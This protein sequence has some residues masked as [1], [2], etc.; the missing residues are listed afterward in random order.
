MAYILKNYSI[1]KLILEVP[2]IIVHILILVLVVS[3]LLFLN[4]FKSILSEVKLLAFWEGFVQFFLFY[5]G[6]K[7][8]IS[9]EMIL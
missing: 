3:G 2:I 7:Y 9:E 5:R 8:P 6:I 4:I 1:G